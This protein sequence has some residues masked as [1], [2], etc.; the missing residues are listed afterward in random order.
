MINKLEKNILQLHECLD[1]PQY[2]D[3]SLTI[4]SS[5]ISICGE[6]TNPQAIQ[7]CLSIFFNKEKNILTF[8]RKAISKDEVFFF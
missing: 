6:N 4:A 2:S 8:L 7:M 1:N 5:I 3:F